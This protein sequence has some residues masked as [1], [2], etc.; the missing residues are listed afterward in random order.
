M[1]LFYLAKPMYGGWISFT[2]HLALKFNYPL[3]RITKR[4]EQ[5][6]RH[7]GYDVFYTNI[8][9]NDISKYNNI[10]CIWFTKNYF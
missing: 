2:S 7:L 10:L 1:N 4:T 8:S 9:P 5:T 6:Q 3:Y